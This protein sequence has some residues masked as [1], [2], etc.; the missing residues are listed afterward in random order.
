M[1]QAFALSYHGKESSFAGIVLG[2]GLQVLRQLID[3]EC[4]QGNL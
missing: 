1:E 2:V 3:P 4:H